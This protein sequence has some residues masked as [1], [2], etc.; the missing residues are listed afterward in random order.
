MILLQV[1]LVKITHQISEQS[2]AGLIGGK[3]KRKEIAD[4][5]I[6]TERKRY[7]QSLPES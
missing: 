5:H 4:L 7:D 1:K 6:R 2:K 3:N